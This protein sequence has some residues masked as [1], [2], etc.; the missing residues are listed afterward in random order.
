MACSLSLYNERG[1][2]YG[3]FLHISLQ[4]EKKACLAEN[5]KHSK[6]IQV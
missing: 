5:I 4:K 3:Y 6:S 1:R 2:S